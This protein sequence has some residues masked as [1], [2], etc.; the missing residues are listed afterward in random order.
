MVV[1]TPA[2][3]PIIAA[4]MVTTTVVIAPFVP[5]HITPI[6]PAIFSVIEPPIVPQHRAISM[7]FVAWHILTLIPVIA[8]KEHPLATGVIRMAVLTPVLGVPRWYTQVNRRAIIRY[9][10][11][12]HRA[13]VNHLRRGCVTNIDTP[14]KARLPN[15]NRHAYICSLCRHHSQRS[16]ERQERLSRFHSRISI[17]QHKP[18]HQMGSVR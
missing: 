14:V 7:P 16:K 1:T 10:F 15:R 11:N 18:T 12:Y 8:H 5:T 6:I 9:A 17:N 4:T 2:I 3:T 13:C